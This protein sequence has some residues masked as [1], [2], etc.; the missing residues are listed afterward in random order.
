MAKIVFLNKPFDVLCQFTDHEQRPT[1]ANYIKDPALKDVYPAGRLDRDSEGLLIL[2][3]DGG[4]QHKISH[5]SKKLSKTYWVQVDGEISEEALTALRTGIPLKD[6]LTKPALAERMDEPEIWT[7]TPSIRVR[8]NIPTS[9][10]TL[11]IQEGKNRQVRRMCAA[12]GFPTLRLIRYAIGQWNLDSLLP[13]RESALNR[14]QPGEYHVE[15]IKSSPSSGTPPP[16]HAKN[17]LTAPKNKARN[18]P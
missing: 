1:L 15:N 3:N 6:G 2:T 7:R 8:K 9:W 11:S 13:P 10:L 12:V 5:P 18:K 16:K 14:L 17:T 4:L